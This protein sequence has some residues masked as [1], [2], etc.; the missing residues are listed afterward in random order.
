MNSATDLA[1]LLAEVRAC[2]QCAPELPLGPRPIVQI[3]AGARILIASQAP[4]RVAHRSGTPFADRSGATLRLWLGMDAATFYDPE[5]VAILPQGLCYPGRGPG[6]DLPPRPEC[7]PLWQRRLH[8][9]LPALRLILP[10]GRHAQ[11]HHLRA[12]CAPTLTETVRRFRDYLPGH[13]PLPHPSGRNGAWFQRHPWFEQE[14]V[15]ALRSEVRRALAG[16]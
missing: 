16:A 11:I 9:Q 7:A 1:A 12:R 13:F 8:A 3:G 14:V 2:R 15:P 10:I 6:G 4:G 5:R